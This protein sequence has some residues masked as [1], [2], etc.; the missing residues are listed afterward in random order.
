M[1][2]GG[3]CGCGS[4]LLKNRA[5]SFLKSLKSCLKSRRCFVDA[6]LL[7]PLSIELSCTLF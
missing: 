4:F 7:M 2:V 6:W 1:T 5:M 3:G